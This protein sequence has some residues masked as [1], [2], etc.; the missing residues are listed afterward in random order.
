MREGSLGYGLVR[1]L[2]GQIG[3]EMEIQT[4]PGLRVAISFPGPSSNSA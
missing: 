2:V 4:E 1:A 3:G